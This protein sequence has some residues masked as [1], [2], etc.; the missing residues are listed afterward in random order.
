MRPLN[1]IAQEW[2]IPPDIGLLSRHVEHAISRRVFI[3]SM[4]AVAGTIASVGLIPGV[5]RASCAA[6]VP[7]ANTMVIAGKTFH[8]TGFGPGIDPSSIYD[9]KGLVGVADVQGTGTGTNPDGSTETLLFD[10]DMRFMSGVYRD[11]DGV[12]H[13]GAFALV[14][15]DLYRGRYD[16]VNFSTQVHDFDPGI[17]P[18]PSGLFWTVPLAQKPSIEL[19]NATAHLCATDLVLADYFDIPNALFRF[20][21]PVS[22]G[23]SCT[24]DLHWS[25]PITS[26][27]PV[28]TPGSSGEL[29]LCQATMTWSAS[30]DLGF[31]FVSNPSPT[32]S[33]FAALGRV[34]NG[35][36]AKD[37]DWDDW[38]TN[39]HCRSFSVG[40]HCRGKARRFQSALTSATTSLLKCSA[41]STRARSFSAATTTVT[42]TVTPGV[43]KA[44]AAPRLMQHACLAFTRQQYPGYYSEPKA[45]RATFL[46]K[47]NARIYWRLHTPCQSS[48]YLY[49]IT[50]FLMG[51]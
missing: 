25:G 13:K 47:I 44:T 29:L 50:S 26:R 5:G 22:V 23:A 4:A 19:D 45:D 3:R 17:H 40:Q 7:T 11:S 6:P 16:F 33:A 24:F 1:F 27:N 37:V 42:Q 51:D 20:Q 43:T 49:F 18:Y 32:T 41:K 39:K 31:S 10:T 2:A 9:F 34:E 12:V 35:V 8:F 46:W 48:V 28:T 14:W 36:F 38:S 15:L 21:T 30:N